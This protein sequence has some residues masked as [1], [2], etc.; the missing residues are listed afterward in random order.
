M[1]IILIVAAIIIIASFVGKRIGSSKNPEIKVIINSSDFNEYD[2]EVDNDKDDNEVDHDNDAWEGSFWDASDP[3][4]ITAHIEID[5]VDGSKSSTTRTVRVREFDNALHGG[6]IMGHCELRN[7]TRTFRF[8]RIKKCIDLETGEVVTD[9]KKYINNR[10]DQSPEKSTDILTIDYVDVLKVIYFMAKADGQYRREEKEVI[11][12]Y[13]RKLVRDERITTKMIDDILKEIDVPTMQGFKLAFSRVLK[14]GE[15][16]PELLATC[17]QEIVNT[18][19]SVHPVEKE[20]LNYIDK[21]LAAL[22][23][24]NA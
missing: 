23:A 20:A 15:V 18:Q 6:I 11:S 22:P 9:V 21:K 8:D 3:K 7:A 1:E 2:N 17:C 5:Y 14:G 12:K 19:K 16:K 10:Y 24:T 4:K 13:V